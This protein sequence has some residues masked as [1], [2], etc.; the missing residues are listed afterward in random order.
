GAGE[1]FGGVVVV[2]GWRTSWDPIEVI[3][4]LR[5]RN[6]HHRTSHVLARKKRA[7][8]VMFVPVAK[9]RGAHAT[10]CL[11]CSHIT[12]IRDADAKL[13]LMRSQGDEDARLVMSQHLTSA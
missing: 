4:R 6:C 3:G 8:K 10:I 9:S 13:W 12:E 11:V 2:V 7:V 1:E 5:C